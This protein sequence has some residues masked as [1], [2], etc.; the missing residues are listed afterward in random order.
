MRKLNALL[1]AFTALTGAAFAA[2]LPAQ[3]SAP[4]AVEPAI[5]WT[6]VYAGLQLGGAF[7][8]T[9][10]TLPNNGYSESWGNNGVIGG[11]HIGYNYQV[12]SFVLGA[13]ASFDL[14]SVKG[15]QTTN[16]AFAPNIFTGSSYHDYIISAD[17]RLGYVYKNLLIYAVGGYAFAANNSALTLNSV[18]IGSVSNTINGYDVGGGVEYALNNQWS[19][20]GEYRYYNF[21]NNTNHFS[22][23]NKTFTNSVFTQ[24]VNFNV[25]RAG[26]S[27]KFAQPEPA[28][29]ATNAKY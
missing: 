14:L 13:E 5:N 2:D 11:G 20:R 4:V 18:Q 19:V 29:V 21:Q 17:G 6:G 7:G 15:S 22:T 16:I 27:Y 28:V 3:K 10:L 23:S 24:S 26:V 8:N 1:L 9:D 12:Q 25:F